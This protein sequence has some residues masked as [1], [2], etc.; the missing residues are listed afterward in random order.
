MTFMAIRAVSGGSAQ[1]AA[2]FPGGTL[3]VEVGLLV[4]L[5]LARELDDR[6][7]PLERILPVDP[8]PFRAHLDHV[9]TGPAVAAEPKR[10][11]GAGCDDEE[12][13]EPPGIGHVLVPCEHQVYV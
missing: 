5:G 8:D 12:V 13:L 7:L 10:R 1:P 3:D 2:P 9:V 6:L 4:L 11:N